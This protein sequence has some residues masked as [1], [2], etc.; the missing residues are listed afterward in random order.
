MAAPVKPATG[1]RLA[2]RVALVTGGSRGIGRAIALAFAREGARVA[3]CARDFHAVNATVRELEQLTTAIGVPADIS[4]P[5]ETAAFVDAAR[6]KLGAPDLLVNNAGTVL[7]RRLED[8]S[9]ADWAGVLGANLH[10]TFHVTREVLPDMRASRRGRII[11]IASIAGQQGTA[12]LTAYCAAKHAVIGLTRALALE[13][14]GAGIQVN[15]IAPGSVD[16]PML[17]QGMP[18]ARPDMTPDD[19]AAAALYLACDAPAAM[20]GQ[21]IDI[22]A[23]GT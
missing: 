4:S 15:A 17:T 3:I 13:V 22:Y 9:D 23:R 16:T 12:E 20:T 6:D 11:N 1:A 7:R 21:V 8:M 5:G 2:G 19:I 10:G 18:G 14:L